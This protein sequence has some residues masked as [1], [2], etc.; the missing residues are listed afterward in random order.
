MESTFL[1]AY[2][3]VATFF[4]IMCM[5]R[6]GGHILKNGARGYSELLVGGTA[7]HVHGQE[8]AHSRASQAICWGGEERQL[9]KQQASDCALAQR[10]Q[11]PPL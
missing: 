7:T 10:L 3:V 4:A 6:S 2:V 5:H 8:L 9:S 11:N 1:Q